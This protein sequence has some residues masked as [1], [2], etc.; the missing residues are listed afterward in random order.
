MMIIIDVVNDDDGRRTSLRTGEMRNPS[1]ESESEWH[2]NW[3]SSEKKNSYLQLEI[4]QRPSRT[5][6]I[7]IIEGKRFKVYVWTLKLSVTWLVTF[8][9]CFCGWLKWLRLRWFIGK[10]KKSFKIAHLSFTIYRSV[11]QSLNSKST[12][13]T[14]RWGRVKRIK[15][16][17]KN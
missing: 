9:L 3:N 11:N 7:M 15:W 8:V 13:F 5:T 16:K 12:L 2:W 1:D 6:T 14:C 4:S 10:A 17:W